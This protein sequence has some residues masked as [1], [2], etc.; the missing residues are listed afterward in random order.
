MTTATQLAAEASHRA[1]MTLGP[2]VVKL[3]GL[4]SDWL[5]LACPDTQH[6][7]AGSLSGISLASDAMRHA[8][9]VHDLAG[10]FEFT[11][12]GGGW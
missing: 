4:S 3:T 5:C 1:T 2:V 8:R 12:F 11:D 9:E 10:E 7:H 6:P